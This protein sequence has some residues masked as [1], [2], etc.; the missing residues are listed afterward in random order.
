MRLGPRC[1]ASF[2]VKNMVVDRR[3]ANESCEKK[4]FKKELK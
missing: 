3:H 1:C 4:M 2:I